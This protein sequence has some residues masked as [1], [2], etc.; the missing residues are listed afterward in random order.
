MAKRLSLETVITAQDNMSAVLRNVTNQLDSFDKKLA[1]TTKKS[2]GWADTMKG[3]IGANL[4]SSGFRFIKD[5]VLE[6]ENAVASFIPKFGGD[7]QRAKAF[8]AELNKVAAETPF[9][10]IDMAKA[11]DMMMGFGVATEKD[12]IPQMKMLGDLA[13]GN[14]ERLNSIALAYSQSMAAGKL[15]MQDVNQLINAGVPILGELAKMYGVNV[16]QIRKM[17][18]QGQIMSK[19]T[20][21]AFRNMTSAGGMFFNGMKIASETTAGKLSTLRDS[22]KQTAVTVAG[23]LV[24]SLKPVIDIVGDVTS[25]F[26]GLPSG[27]QSGL[28][29]AG[30]LIAMF[31][32][33]LKSKIGGA[34]AI[35]GTLK[36]AL[37]DLLDTQGSI[38]EADIIMKGS[39]QRQAGVADIKQRIQAI[40]QLEEGSIKYKQ[41]IDNLA[42][43]HP[44][45]RGAISSASTKAQLATYM[46]MLERT[47]LAQM[48]SRQQAAYNALAEAQSQAGT[49]IISPLYGKQTGISSAQEMAVI[50]I[51]KLQISGNLTQRGLEE[52]QKNYEQ[53]TR[54][55]SVGQFA[56]PFGGMAALSDKSIY[57]EAF[58]QKLVEAYKEAQKNQPPPPPQ[59]I[60]IRVSQDGRVTDVQTTKQPASGFKIFS[61]IAFNP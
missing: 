8:V 36:S 34:I 3:M 19:D 55:M 47:N 30:G 56:T 51:R 23:P 21:K 40:N 32:G 13:G 57:Y 26:A 39:A 35:V 60:N 38:A 14:A 4:A 58:K 54:V 33:G 22:L 9:E 61:Q 2:A 1:H 31:V 53:L 6:T 46:S 27:I 52:E 50:A 29:A 5:A 10:F 24:N 59:E 18:E 28:V 43:S 15:N 42:T 41:A 45:L 48:Q 11:A 49:K 20:Q 16:G 37:D 7:M 12:V 44:E 17:I 25:A